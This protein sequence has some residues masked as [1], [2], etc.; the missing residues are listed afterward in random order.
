MVINETIIRTSCIETAEAMY[1][2]V[3]I[4]YTTRCPVIFRYHF[5]F[6]LPLKI[7]F[8]ECAS[9]EYMSN[10]VEPCIYSK[11]KQF[12]NIYRKNFNHY[13]VVDWI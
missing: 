1:P 11:I 9:S 3:P 5:V 4:R 7:V 8:S 12:N 13:R 2:I 6:P 10:Y